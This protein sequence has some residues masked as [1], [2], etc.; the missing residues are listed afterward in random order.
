[1]SLGESPFLLSIRTVLF[2]SD[3]MEAKLRHFYIA[4][5]IIVTTEN[6]MRPSIRGEMRAQQNYFCRWPIFFQSRTAERSR[7]KQ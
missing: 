4:F 7:L 2:S 5:F 3:E 1:M 6:H